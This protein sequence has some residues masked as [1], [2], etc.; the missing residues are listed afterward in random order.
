MNLFRDKKNIND[1]ALII[2]ILI[3][4]GLF[5]GL[6]HKSSKGSVVSVTDGEGNSYS[7]S[8]LTDSKNVLKTHYGYNVLVIKD[9]KAFISEADCPNCECIKQGSIS[10]DGEMIFC[11]PHKLVIKVESDSVNEY[12]S[13]S[14]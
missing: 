4:A 1:I 9:G 3:I 13:V 11:M 12:D 8:L 6:N 5:F 7:Y 2:G 10:N 14:Y